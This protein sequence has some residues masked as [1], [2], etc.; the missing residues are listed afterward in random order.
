MHY[1]WKIEWS[2]ELQK[3]QETVPKVLLKKLILKKKGMMKGVETKSFLFLKKD[4]NVR[5]D[6]VYDESSKGDWCYGVIGETNK[7]I[8]PKQKPLL[9]I[10]NKSANFQNNLT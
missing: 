4:W 7:S 6:G 10:V 3:P 2:N 5:V 9:P 8:N 1:D